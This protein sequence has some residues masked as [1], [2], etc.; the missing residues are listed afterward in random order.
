[1]NPTQKRVVVTT[2]LL[3]GLVA[4][5]FG[6]DGGNWD[7][8][9]WLIAGIVFCGG[10]VFMA[11]IGPRRPDPKPKEEDEAPPPPRRQY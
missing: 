11:T 6:Y 4:L 9:G 7:E 3:V 8:P 10:A 5:S 2:I 1:M